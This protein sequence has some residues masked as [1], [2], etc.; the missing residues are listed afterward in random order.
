MKAFHILLAST[1]LALPLPA[2]AQVADAPAADTAQPTEDT[3]AADADIIVTGVARGQNRLDS[4]VSVSSLDQ[5]TLQTTAP[6]SVAELFRNIPGV[7]SES[8]GGEGNA[9]IAV[10]GLPVASGGSKFLQLQ[11]GMGKP[12]ILLDE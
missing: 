12:W 9:N 4:S 2:M 1:A 7:R 5:A 11:E 3:A 8:S 6:R 10:R